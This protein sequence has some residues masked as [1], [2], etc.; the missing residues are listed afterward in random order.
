MHDGR[1]FFYLFSTF[2]F[3]LSNDDRNT[4]T[5]SLSAFTLGN[6]AFPRKLVLPSAF[7]SLLSYSHLP[8]GSTHISQWLLAVLFIYKMKR[9]HTRI[10][11]RWCRI[12]CSSSDFPLSLQHVFFFFLNVLLANWLHRH[13]SADYHQRF[14][15]LFQQR[16]EL[17]LNLA[18]ADWIMRIQPITVVVGQPCGV[19]INRT[20][21]VEQNLINCKWW[22][23]LEGLDAHLYVGNNNCQ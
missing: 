5:K 20:H 18:S 3:P 17:R 23:S 7:P 4:E 8:V 6:P 11:S 14:Q 10:N 12:P 2:V 9:P 1:C 16:Q 19:L 13:P 15:S 21:V 22:S